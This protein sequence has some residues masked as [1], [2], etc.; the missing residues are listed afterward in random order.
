MYSKGRNFPKHVRNWFFVRVYKV[1]GK[2]SLSPVLKRAKAL[3][4]VKISVH[5][6]IKKIQ[7]NFNVEI[8][9]GYHG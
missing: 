2:I 7:T 5:I 1:G 4:L 9:G 8:L 6:N 3:F